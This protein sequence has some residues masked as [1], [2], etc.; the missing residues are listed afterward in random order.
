MKLWNLSITYIGLYIGLYLGVISGCLWMLSKKEL[1]GICLCKQ[2]TN[3]EDSSRTII[4][5]P[6][7]LLK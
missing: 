6:S 4:I 3:V 2:V 7:T 1:K 5:P